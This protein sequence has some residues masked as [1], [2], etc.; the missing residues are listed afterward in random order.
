MLSN[1]AAVAKICH[2]HDGCVHA[3]RDRVHILWVCRLGDLTK[4]PQMRF[5][6]AQKLREFTSI[7]VLR[8]IE[9]KASDTNLAHVIQKACHGVLH[10]AARGA[11]VWEA[12]EIT[13]LHVPLVGVVRHETIPTRV[14]L[15]VMHVTWGKDWSGPSAV[16]ASR[17]TG[18][19]TCSDMIDD[20]ICINAD[21]NSPTALHHVDES[22]L[23]PRSADQ[24]V[25]HRLIPGPPRIACHVFIRRRDLH[26]REALRPQPL[27][28]LCSNVCPRPL[29]K[30]DEG[31]T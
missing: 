26:T 9:A 24:P 15:K 14:T 31:R 2:I 4:L 6:L 5:N 13:V 23:I 19:V 22:Q 16:A 21:S 1:E 25:G 8:R 20:G 30:V 11:E 7:L 17:D 28:A 27:L 29:E 12:K 18:A 3:G 10:V